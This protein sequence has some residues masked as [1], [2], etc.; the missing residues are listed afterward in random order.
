MFTQSKNTASQPN[1]FYVTLIA[2]SAALGGFL[3]GFD[4][5]VINSGLPI[6]SFLPPFHPYLKPLA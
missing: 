2:A 4:T 1:A 5:A 3:F 6:F